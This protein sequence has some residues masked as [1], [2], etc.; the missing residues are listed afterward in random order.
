MNLYT[1]LNPEYTIRGT[2]FKDKSIALKTIKLITDRSALYQFQVINT[3][4]NRARYHPHKTSDIESAITVFKHWL[5]VDYPRIRKREMNYPYLPLKM[6]NN[7]EPLAEEYGISRVAR[8]LDKSTKSDKG[9]LVV[10]RQVK[11]HASKL[12]YIP[13]KKKYPHKNDWHKLREKFINARLGQIKA[14]KTKWFYTAGKYAGLPTKQ[15]LVLIMNGYSPYYEK[16]KTVVKL[17]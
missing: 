1:D 11:G 16:L 17:L 12:I 3:L 8:G 5:T 9:F 4:Y 15:H 2:G 14:K 6:I 13:A 7:F 10:Y